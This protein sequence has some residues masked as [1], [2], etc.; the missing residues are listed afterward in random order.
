MARGDEFIEN[1]VRAA[2]LSA[3][4]NNRDEITYRQHILIDCLRNSDVEGTFMK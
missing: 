2:V 1:I 4:Y 3:A